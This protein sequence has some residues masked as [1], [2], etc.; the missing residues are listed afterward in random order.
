MIDQNHLRQLAAGGFMEVES[1]VNGVWNAAIHQSYPTANVEYVVA[2]EVRIDDQN[3]LDLLVRSFTYSAGGNPTA[4]PVLLF[5]GKGSSGDSWER[6]ESQLSGYLN[7]PGFLT[8]TQ[9][10]WAL[11]GRGK[12]MKLWRFHK[13]NAEFQ[14]LLPWKV[15]RGAAKEVPRERAPPPYSVVDNY[16]E[17]RILL[18]Y[19]HNHPDPNF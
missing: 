9:K 11:G 7:R 17:V 12:D 1:D 10:C 2:P 13:A 3:R 19:I 4:K 16:D 18:D 5:E 15:E 14:K 8:P 6:L